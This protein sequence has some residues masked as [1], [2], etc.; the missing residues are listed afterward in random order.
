MDPPSKG[1]DNHAT[2]F[3]TPVAGLFVEMSNCNTV[4]RFRCT[5]CNA[6]FG[7]KCYAGFADGVCHGC[8]RPIVLYALKPAWLGRH[9]IRQR[10]RTPSR[11]AKRALAIANNSYDS[12][13]YCR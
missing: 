13:L 8:D 11:A 5:H 9:T 12:G 4:Y 6:K 3:D 2:Y 1:W 7:R 10:H